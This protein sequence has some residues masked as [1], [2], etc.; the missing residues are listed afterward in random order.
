MYKRLALSPAL[1]QGKPRSDL[2]IDSSFSTR[3]PTM[4]LSHS[5][6]AI[7]LFALALTGVGFA[8]PLAAV[9][10]ASTHVAVNLSSY[11]CRPVRTRLRPSLLTRCA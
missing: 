10:Y 8:T 11:I 5:F 1:T 6:S 7:V 4:Q 3:T 9:S 2:P